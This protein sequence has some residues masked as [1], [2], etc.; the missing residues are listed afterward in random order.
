M[1]RRSIESYGKLYLQHFFTSHVVWKRSSTLNKDNSS[2]SWFQVW[3]LIKREGKS[4]VLAFRRFLISELKQIRFSKGPSFVMVP[5]VDSFKV[6]SI[7]TR[8][9]EQRL[10]NVFFP[11]MLPASN[12]SELLLTHV[13]FFFSFF[14]PLPRAD[15]ARNPSSIATEWV[16]QNIQPDSISTLPC[17]PNCWNPWRRFGSLNYEWN[18]ISLRLY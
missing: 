9:R 10:S 7:I 3:Y 17:S 4:N 18:E 13:C 8:L 2:N 11:T 12:I 14:V 15:R 5:R 16:S 6:T 1:K